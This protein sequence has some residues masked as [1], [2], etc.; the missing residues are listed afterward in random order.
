MYYQVVEL[1]WYLIVY[2]VITEPAV[3]MTTIRPFR[4]QDLFKFNNVNLDPLT[5]NY[6]L[7][8]YF[9]YLT[10]W[11]ELFQVCESTSGKIMGY[12]MGK[13]EAR[14]SSQE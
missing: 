2:H 12:Y 9:Y 14:H 3:T 13:S 5:E 7:S 1:Y 6:N 11:P 4:C 8:F 10:H